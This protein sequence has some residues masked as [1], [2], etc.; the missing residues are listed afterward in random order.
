MQ[1]IS[2]RHIAFTIG[3]FFISTSSNGQSIDALQQKLQKFE[4]QIANLQD[5]INMVQEKI[6][7][8]QVAASTVHS[9]DEKAIMWQDRADIKMMPNV[10]STNIGAL[11]RGD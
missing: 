4:R 7:Q 5:S 9:F 10:G 2:P 8:K 11:G 3:G 6:K 1:L